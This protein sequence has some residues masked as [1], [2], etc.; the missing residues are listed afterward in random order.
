MWECGADSTVSIK[1]TDTARPEKNTYAK[2]KR[3]KIFPASSQD[4]LEWYIGIDEHRSLTAKYACWNSIS[5][6]PERGV[7][8]F[9]GTSKIPLTCI[10]QY[11]FF[12]SNSRSGQTMLFQKMN[13]T[14]D[15]KTRDEKFIFCPFHKKNGR[16]WNKW[17]HLPVKWWGHRRTWRGCKPDRGLTLLNGVHLDLK[18]IFSRSRSS[19]RILYYH[20][21][22]VVIWW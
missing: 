2:Q 4:H 18:N 19:S 3:V 5:N 15:E 17:K 10:E 14:H 1:N 9:P 13:T 16:W 22:L 8:T 11:H 12:K 7:G 6:F 21:V 20:G